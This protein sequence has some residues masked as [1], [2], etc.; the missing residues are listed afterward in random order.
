MYI[1][2]YQ[3][4]HDFIIFASILK[5]KKAYKSVIRTNNLMYLNYLIK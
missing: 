3:L 2:M 4:A 5:C 1:Y